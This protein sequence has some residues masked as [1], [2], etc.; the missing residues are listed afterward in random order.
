MPETPEFKPEYLTQ[1]S[2]DGSYNDLEQPA[3]GRAG[4]RFGRNMPFERLPRDDARAV[5]EPNPRVVSR[6]LLTRHEFSPR[7]RSTRWPRRGC[8][9]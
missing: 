1:R 6:E 8:S 9:S 5:L 4:S 2:P 7:R 3:M